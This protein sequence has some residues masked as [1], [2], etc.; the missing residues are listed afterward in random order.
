VELKEGETLALDVQYTLKGVIQ[1]K[2][3]AAYVN[4]PETVCRVDGEI[5][6]CLGE[7]PLMLPPLNY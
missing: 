6:R 1:D 4:S 5:K 3:P 2:A 7:S